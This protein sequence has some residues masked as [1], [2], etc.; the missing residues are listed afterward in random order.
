MTSAAAIQEIMIY[1]RKIARPVIITENKLKQIIQEEL[2]FTYR[3]QLLS[4][5]KKATQ[6]ISEAADAA[7][8][9]IVDASD[10][11]AAAFSDPTETASAIITALE[12][13]IGIRRDKWY[14]ENGN[15]KPE[16]KKEIDPVLR[17]VGMISKQLRNSVGAKV[18]IEKKLSVLATIGK[19][20]SGVTFLT[21]FYKLLT[22]STVDLVTAMEKITI[23]LS[24][25][26]FVDSDTSFNVPAGID[27]V[28]EFAGLPW[29]EAGVYIA[30]ASLSVA[31]IA[32]LIKGG[33]VA[34]VMVHDAAAAGR[35][36]GKII[37]AAA[38]LG[39]IFLTGF[40][41]IAKR[42]TSW[43]TKKY[44]DWQSKRVT[45]AETPKV[46]MKEIQELQEILNF[47][48]HNKYRLL[49]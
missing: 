34:K 44:K 5:V 21:G 16:I 48:G 37:M 13:Q 6:I 42:L 22:Q 2:M 24:K 40:I 46:A 9:E 25:L 1:A 20:T 19:Y 29:L 18:P 17:Q 43:A 15:M 35:L 4:E 33:K 10:Q 39:K 26:P 28:T 41:S 45:S 27:L 38:K 3:D 8:T 31:A 23:P 47:M 7:T 12:Q 14:D 49:T 32:K 30:A 36:L 11:I